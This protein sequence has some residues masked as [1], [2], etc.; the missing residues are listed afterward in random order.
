MAGLN[1]TILNAPVPQSKAKGT[2]PLQALDLSDYDFSTTRYPT[3]GLGTDDVPHYVIFNI[4]LPTNSKF[5][6]NT[7]TVANAQSS[8]QQN[9]AIKNSLG[10]VYQASPG[11]AAT[12]GVTA[13]ALGFVSGEGAGALGTGAKAA[14][15]T[16]AAGTIDLQPKLARIKKAIAIYMPDTMLTNYDH[17]WQAVSM[18]EA[19]GKAGQAAAVGAGVLNIIGT[20]GES[21]LKGELPALKG[22]VFNS[23]QGAEAVGAIATAAGAGNDFTDLAL[24]GVNAAINPLVEMVFRGTHNR[25]YVFEFQFQPRS[26]AEAS[27]IQDIIKTFRMYAAPEINTAANKSL[28]GS[29]RYFTPPAQFDIKFFFKNVENDNIAKISTC[30]LTNIAVNYSGA[31]QFASFDD[32]QPVQINVALTFKEMDVITRELINTYGY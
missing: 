19:L 25:G 6:S 27:V 5:L 7:N 23:A 31:G 18:T 28:G 4:N 9:Y 2:G 30:A 20:S 22:G 8:S 14:G 12:A 17:D 16:V 15:V 13:G 11:Q 21:L 29:G 3:E 1:A 24:R 10:G 26:A 32:G